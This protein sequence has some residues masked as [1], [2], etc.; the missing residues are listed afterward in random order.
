MGSFLFVFAVGKV[1]QGQ[2]IITK[3]NLGAGKNGKTYDR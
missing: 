1:I 3:Y 2:V